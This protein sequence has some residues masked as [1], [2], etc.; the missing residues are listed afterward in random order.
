MMQECLKPHPLLHALSG[1]GLGLVIVALV[2]GLVANAL[3]L[4]IILIVVGLVLEMMLGK[5][6]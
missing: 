4:G 1:I 5:K 3:T 2:P 6:K